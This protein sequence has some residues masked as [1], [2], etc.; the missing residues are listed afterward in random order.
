MVSSWTKK[1][2]KAAGIDTKRFG[3][4]STRS[5]STSAA[6]AAGINVNTLMQQANWKRADTFAKHYNKPIEDVT[7]SVTYKVIKQLRK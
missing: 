1:V 5:A 2:L 4:H 3:A 7:G 6:L